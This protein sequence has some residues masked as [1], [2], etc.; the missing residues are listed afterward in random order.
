MTDWFR[1]ITL[2]AISFVGVVVVTLG[3]AALIVPAPAVSSQGDG[4]GSPRA[5]A[6]AAAPSASEGTPGLGGELA[7][8]G[9]REGPFRVQTEV[10]EGG[11]ALAGNEGRIVFGGEV[12]EVTQVSFDGLEFFPDPGQCT[13]STLDLDAQRGL[14]FADIECVEISDI[15]DNGVISIAGT[16]GMSLDH[17]AERPFPNQGG[18]VEVG[19]ETW[20]FPQ[21]FLITW[22]SP[23]TSGAG[24]GNYNMELLDETLGAGLFFTYDESHRAG[25]LDVLRDGEF[26]A[27]PDGAC[28][29]E[30]EVLG[31]P[32]TL[33]TTV[34]LTIECTAVEVPGLGTVPI[35]GTVV[36]DELGFPF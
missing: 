12:A 29:I 11:Y 18:T 23:A 28:R 10:R 32:N 33:D 14:G 9:D 20:T 22:Q 30:R 34:E 35:S 4:D 3:I 21:A 25:L 7:V 36:V 19:D 2:L 13:V 24:H 15:R 27:V 1:S 8:T 6:A 26:L 17:L 16:V 5:S 31:M